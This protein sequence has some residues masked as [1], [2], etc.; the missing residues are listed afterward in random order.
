MNIIRKYVAPI[1][2]RLQRILHG[3]EPSSLYEPCRYVLENGGKRFRPVLT[4]LAAG[5]CGEKTEKAIPAALSVELIHN[6][7]LVHDDIMDD[8][9]SRRGRPTVHTKWDMPVAILAGDL[10]YTEAFRQ[11]LAYK[12]DSSVGKEQF[13]LLYNTLLDAIRVVCEGQAL[14]MELERSA[15]ATTGEYLKM[16]EGKTS[17][18]IGGSLVM[19]GVVASADKTRLQSLD[20]LGRIIGL[21]FQIQDDLLDVI[22]DPDKFGKIRGGDILE[23]KKTYL[24]LRALEQSNEIQRH[25]LNILTRKQTT[26]ADVQRVIQLYEQTEAISQTEIKVESYYQEAVDLLQSFDDS[27][28]KD[29]LV[30]LL[31][32][33][34]NREF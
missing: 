24:F 13:S 34:K 26:P 16:I 29:D 7:T 30:A 9:V 14:D 28:Y 25:E 27:I 33:L 15:G 17:A 10:L 12:E 2:D 19:G 5:M 3:R 32:F 22:A 21:A 1:E 6:F 8:A 4:L 11:L 31:D 20:R 18:L 23:G